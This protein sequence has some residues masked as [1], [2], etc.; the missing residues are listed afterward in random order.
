M[1]ELE[2][3][4][5]SYFAIEK[6]DLSIIENLFEKKTLAKNE[7][8]SVADK[9]CNSLSF[10]KSGALRVFN[11]AEG[12]EIT[13]WISS[14]G[15]FVTDLSSLI[16]DQP[17]RWNIQTVTNCELYTISKEN[18]QKIG[19]LVSQWKDLEKLFIAKCFLTLE[20]RVFT[21]LSMTAEERYLQFIEEKKGLFNEVPH[22][23]IASL[24][25]MTPETLSRIRKKTI[26]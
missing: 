24:L 6:Q 19:G 1:T 4:I 13:Q 26:S 5:H 9:T 14:K 8:I 12:K 16:F 23:Y 22:T 25:G 2:Q 18:Y 20:E 21:F 15:E 3:Y 17:A 7:Y 11:Y 10:I